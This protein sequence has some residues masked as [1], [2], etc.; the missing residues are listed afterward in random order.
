VIA[1]ALAGR[2][3]GAFAFDAYPLLHCATSAATF[4][5]CA[6]LIAVALFPFLDRRGV[7]R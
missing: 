3:A 5:M 4:W 1:I 2:L 6:A 7:V